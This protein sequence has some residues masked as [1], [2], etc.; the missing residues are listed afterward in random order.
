M[1]MTE[2]DDRPAF[3]EAD[4]RERGT[5]TQPHALT[6]IVEQF[7]RLENGLEDLLTQTARL[8]DRLTPVL[9]PPRDEDSKSPGEDTPEMSDVAR[10][11]DGMAD[12]LRG[13]NRR[14]GRLVER[15]DL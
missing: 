12:R 7:D 6:N 2:S 9:M 1:S 13:I 11:L 10:R 5:R 3:D 14:L 15:I 8:E 4:R